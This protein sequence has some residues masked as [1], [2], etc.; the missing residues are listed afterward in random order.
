MPQG[1]DTGAR[2]ASPLLLD[3]V[4]KP[5]ADKDREE[6]SGHIE[7]I[8]FTSEDDGFTVAKVRVEGHRNLVTAV[9]PMAQPMPGQ[10][11]TI[12]GR[13]VMDKRYG[14]QFRVES[15]AAALPTSVTG[16]RLYLGSGQIKGIGPRYAQRI[17]DAFG[18]NTLDVI[19]HDPKKLLEIEGIGAGRLKKIVEG[20]QEQ[21]ESR[22]LM[23]FLQSHG[24]GPG[25]AVRIFRAYGR[26]SLDMVRENPYRLAEEISGIG[27]LTA[28]AIAQK[29]GFAKDS[30]MRL[31]AGL[32]YVMSESMS[33]GHVYMP[34]HVLLDRASEIL[35][36]ERTALEEPL[37]AL[38]LQD[39]LVAEHFRG[40]EEPAIYLPRLHAS[41]KIVARRLLGLCSAP[42]SLRAMDAEKAI[43]WVQEKQHITLAPKQA[44]AIRMAAR[45]KVLV[46]T[47]GP[48]TGKTTIIRAILRIFSAMGARALL[49]AP[50]GRAA[51]RMAE[52]CQHEAKTIHRLLEYGPQNGG[53]HRNES[54][55]L[56]CQ[57][58]IVDEA[59]MVDI[60]L[61]HQLLMAIPMGATVVFVGDSNQLPSVGPGNVLSDII[62]S[63]AVPVV[64][65][66]EIFRQARQSEIVMSA[67]AIN[68]GR[69]PRLEPPT[70]GSLTDFYF[71][72]QEDPEQA[73]EMVVELVKERIP[74]RFGLDPL[75]DVQVL[76]P[77]HKGACGA[78]RLNEK[79]QHALNRETTVLKRGK[80]VFRLGDKV[81]QVRNNY[82]KDVFN[83][84]IGRVV[85]VDQD[86][87]CLTVRFDDRD[88][89][90]EGGDLEDVV[91][92]YAV[93]VHKSQGSEYPAV[94]VPVLLEHYV[95]LQRNL[96]YTAVT[97]GRRLVV[98]VGS[99]KAL[100]IAVRNNAIRRRHTRLAQRLAKGA[101]NG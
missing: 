58:L 13:W 28:D 47:G 80:K 84:D 17:V 2:N 24:V 5:A 70:D 78:A 34:E 52:T 88:V 41:E 50:T 76:S 64:E 19:E 75:E 48:G 66:D 89:D 82:E 99:K 30:P 90:L 69:L 25:L 16:I 46:V 38:T 86:N 54:N 49:A 101:S 55:P 79:L 74:Q 67:H 1:R 40:E 60:S 77:M 62:E 42:K 45:E 100:A 21:R 39:R 85:K 35:G 10:A 37:R 96:L 32:H 61:M 18:I 23:L 8:T 12:A 81:M 98:V 27:F 33:Q 44:D 83:G 4:E 22:D 95:L 43:A 11:V 53:F 65:L 7:S 68:E 73:A 97:R 3:G 51:K 20:W 72:R 29:L 9:G 57:L 91:S 94:V 63:G 6:L 31:E 93:S 87:A 15:S 56:S 92:A 71:V 26:A 14:E 59:S 36:A